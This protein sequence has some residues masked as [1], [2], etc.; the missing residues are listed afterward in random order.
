MGASEQN[1]K[2][3]G[4]CADFLRP[5]IYSH[6]CVIFHTRICKELQQIVS[7][8]ATFSSRVMRTGFTVMTL[9]LSNNLPPP[10]Q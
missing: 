4:E 6:V 3:L 7:D 9:K 1:F 10:P 8:D 5:F 2:Q